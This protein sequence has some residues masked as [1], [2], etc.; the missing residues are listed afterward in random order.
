MPVNQALRARFEAKPEDGVAFAALEEAYFVAGEWSE[1]AALYERRL[2]ATDLTAEKQPKQR[3]RVLQRLAQAREERL[4]DGDGA[5]A[6]YR[7]ATALDPTLRAAITQLRRLL[8]KRDEWDTV[9]ALADAEAKLPM[10]PSERAQLASEIGALWLEKRGDAANARSCYEQ[11]L[12]AEATYAPAL[13]GLANAAEQAG[14]LSTAAASLEKASHGLQGAER[15]AALARLANLQQRLGDAS[16]ASENFRKALSDDPSQASAL[17]ALAARAEAGQKWSAFDDLQDRRFALSKDRLEKL[18]IAH[19]AGRVQLERAN[20][21][22]NARKWFRRALDLFPND[23]VVHLYLSDVERALGNTEALAKHLKRATELAGDAAPIDALSESAQLESARG[24][25]DVA[26]DQLRKALAREPGRNDVATQLAD[27]LA[28]A[29]REEEFVELVESQLSERPGGEREVALW[30]RLGS[31]H[32]E[33]RGDFATALD[34]YAQALDLARANGAAIAGYER[35][36]RKLEHWDALAERLR[37]AA[38]AATGADAA[39]L[40]VRVGDLRLEREDLDG[41]KDGYQAALAANPDDRRARQGVERISLATADDE[42]ILVAFER[43]AEETSD[44]ERL[45]F[46]VCELT[47]IHEE[48]GNAA[49]ALHWLRRLATVRPEDAAVLAHAARLQAAVGDRVGE[50]ATLQKLDPRISGEPQLV[51][52]RRIAALSHELGEPAAALAAHRAV[53]ALRPEEISSARAVVELLASSDD[54]DAQV[55][56][57]RHLASVAS[58]DERTARGYE[59]ACLLMDRVGDLRAAGAVLENVVDAQA[60]PHDAEARFAEVLG[61]IGRWD[62]LCAR[63]DLRRRLLDPLD[64][65][66]LELDLQRA[67]LL[68]DR[69]DRA[70]D[71][72]AIC[73]AVREASPRHERARRAG[74]G[75]AQARRRH[76]PGEA[77]L[78]ALGAGRRRRAARIARNGARAAARGAPARAAGSA[79]GARRD[80]EQRQRARRRSGAA[81]APD[82]R[83]LAG[84]G[85]AREALRDLSRLRRCA[86][87]RRRAQAA[88]SDRARSHARHAPRDRPPR[89]RTRAHAERPRAASPAAERTRARGRRRAVRRVRARA[90]ARRHRRRA[91][92]PSARPLRGAAR[93]GERSGARRNASRGARCRRRRHRPLD[94][95]PRRALRAERAPPA[96]RGAAAP[97]H[98]P[99]RE[100]PGE[101]RHRA[102][103]ARAARSGPALRARC[104][105]RNARSRCRER[106]HA[107]DR[108]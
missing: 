48:R 58:G 79:R 38:Q 1:L 85:G 60:A 99:A 59:L 51:N 100:R 29:G 34:A 36:A 98:R 25:G 2:G 43:E 22:Q 73:E 69:L 68:V 81:T 74:A 4:G 96:A 70:A 83:E 37:S 55:A 105:A 102:A 27:A 97:A 65:R 8:T 35:V 45:A 39:Q 46:L 94:A 84:L 64:P 56:A 108:E 80:R 42:A 77:A 104:R 13:L 103:P 3:A 88:R 6:A 47:R 78:R 93:A 16:R 91:P 50:L 18:A 101:R 28:A 5:I 40:W 87:G 10:R 33:E 41:A 7:E 23:P 54:L 53:L 12:A 107:R 20:D 66:S 82:A 17:A 86:S 89:E 32:E 9:L 67:E 63:L 106:R 90:R 72:A 26:I 71:A 49:R 57:L 19:D 11:A 24:A 76:A 44:R 14:D 15:G 62:V 21:P 92:A 31:F 30:V 52:R 95:V 75:A 61:Q